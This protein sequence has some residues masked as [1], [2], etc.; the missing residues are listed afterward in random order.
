MR[1]T[2]LSLLL[3]AFPLFASEPDPPG[4]LALAM[5]AGWEKRIL[6]SDDWHP[7]WAAIGVICSGPKGP[8][9]AI[10]HTTFNE[11][12]PAGQGLYLKAHPEKAP[13]YFNQ[14][15]RRYFAL[16]AEQRRLIDEESALVPKYL[17]GQQ[18]RVEA[19]EKKTPVDSGAFMSSADRKR[20]VDITVRL[21]QLEAEVG[22][23]LEQ[24][25]KEHE[26]L[27]LTRRDP[28]THLPHIAGAK[29][30]FSEFNHSLTRADGKARV[31]V[32]L[33]P[34]SEPRTALIRS[35]I[36]LAIVGKDWMV[37]STEFSGAGSAEVSY[38]AVW[39]P[40]DGAS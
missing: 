28:D 22:R 21:E 3:L 13:E 1:I 7:T 39:P 33:E 6:P 12:E 10:L 2:F 26:S 31:Y 24:E 18:A 40:V 27:F 8:F 36:E 9:A 14:K 38:C 23:L 16:A 35:R 4:D 17:R 32:R 37:K 25:A 19:S 11:L 5:A 34:S 15:A 30:P 20:E 29:V